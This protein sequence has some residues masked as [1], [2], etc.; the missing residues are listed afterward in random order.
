MTWHLHKLVP[1]IITAR[2]TKLREG[3][4][5][6]PGGSLSLCPGGS[7]SKGEVSVQGGE[8]SVQGGSLSGGGGSRFS[9]F[10]CLFLKLF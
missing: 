8:V 3:G 4:G 9:V 7:L 1:V 6:Y 5:L 2:K 10:S